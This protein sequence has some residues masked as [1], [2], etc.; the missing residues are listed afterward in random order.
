MGKLLEEMILQRLQGHMVR[1]DGLSE[2]QF[3][4]W[5]GRSAVDTIQAVVDIATKAR[6][7]TGKRKGFCGLISIDI[8]NA[9]NTVRWNICIQAKVR[10]KVPDYLLRMISDY[11]SDRWVICEGDKWSLKEEMTCGAPQGSR[12]GAVVWNVMYDDFLRMDIPAGTSII[13]FADDALVVC[14]ADVRILELRINESMCR[15]KRWL[16]SRC[17][18]TAPEKTEIL[19][20]TDRRSFKYPRIF[21]G[22]HEIKWKKSIKYLGV[23]LDR[24]LS[25]GEHLQIA[26]AKPIQYG[27]ALTWLM[28]NIGGPREAKRRL[29]ASVIN[30]KL[31]HAALIWTSALNNHATLKKLFSAQRGV[32]MRIVSAYRTVSTSAVVVLASVRPI[33]L[34]AEERKETFKLHKELT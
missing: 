26:T 3:G 23:Q 19:L 10:K 11:L 25:F 24:R 2:N 27:A 16:D 29:V 12:L 4:F 15:A 5:K 6:R 20:V 17:L 18:K 13:G 30:S 33:D 14:A 22:E 9:F 32:V 31:L 34:L 7:G 1:E 8:R 28:P 21:L